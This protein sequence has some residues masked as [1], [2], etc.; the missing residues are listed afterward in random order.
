MPILSN[1]RHEAFCQAFVTSG[2]ASAAYRESGGNG[3]NADVMANQLMR[4]NGIAERIAELKG[5][6]VAKAELT[7]ANMLAFLASVIRDESGEMRNRLRAVELLAKMLGWNEPE[8]HEIE[9][10]FKE[11]QEFCEAEDSNLGS[12]TLRDSAI[13]GR[14]QFRRAR[15]PAG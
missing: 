4:T 11:R 9:H 1:P 14:S 6:A 15:R 8:K 13:A 2:N 10:G 12:T 7:R 3:R 5:E